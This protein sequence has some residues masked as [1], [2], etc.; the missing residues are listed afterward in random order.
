MA[1][2]FQTTP[3]NVTIH[4]ASLYEEGEF[5]EAATCK[6]YLQVRSEGDRQD[7]RSVKHYKVDIFISVGYRVKEFGSFSPR[8]PRDSVFR[9][10]G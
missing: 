3:Q 9:F 7:Q 4:I 5:E 8:F 10:G 1:E 2:L 6:E